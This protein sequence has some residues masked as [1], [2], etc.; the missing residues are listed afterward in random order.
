LPGTFRHRPEGLLFKAMLSP[1]WGRGAWVSYYRKQMFPSSPPADHAGYVTALKTNLGEPGRYRAFRALAF[2]S[3]AESESRL[4][5][6]NVPVLIIM[7]TADPDFPDPEA[8][9]RGLG[10]LLDGSVVLVDGVGHY[11]Q[12][13]APDRTAEAI[14]EFLR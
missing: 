2:N 8:E 10:E 3:H 1:P 6:V 12:A 7:G 14:S 5:D 9:A 4:K 11:P 13:E